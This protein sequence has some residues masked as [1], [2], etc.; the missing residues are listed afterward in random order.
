MRTVAI[1]LLIAF[2]FAFVAMPVVSACGGM[3]VVQPPSLTLE[4]PINET[5]G[6]SPS[7]WGSGECIL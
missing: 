5:P 6:G 4:D 3:T 2:A 1:A 7:E